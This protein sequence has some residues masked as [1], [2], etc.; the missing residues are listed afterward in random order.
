[1][2]SIY[3]VK[4]AFQRVLQPACKFLYRAG[5]TPNQITIA[6]FVASVAM[7]AWLY[8]S[9]DNKMP[10]IVLPIFLFLRMAANALDGMLARQ[11]DLASEAGALLNE[12]CDVLAD[13]ALYLPF[14]I[15]PGMQPILIITIVILAIVS[16]VVSLAAITIGAQRRVD[17]PMG[18]S[19]RAVAF[20]FAALL[21]GFGFISVEKLNYLFVVVGMLLLFTIINRYK[22]ALKEVR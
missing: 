14:A 22:N 2:P 17:G 10:Y 9:T 15:I 11:Y 8:I 5:I 20:G 6:T 21:Y 1:M 12:I 3:S 19:D 16:E 4:P 13:A 7:G 18:K